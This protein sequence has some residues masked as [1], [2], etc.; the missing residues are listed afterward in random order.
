MLAALHHAGSRLEHLI[1]STSHIRGVL[2]NRHAPLVNQVWWSFGWEE[3]ERPEEVLKGARLGHSASGWKCQTCRRSLAGT[4]E[5]CC[6]FLRV[7]Y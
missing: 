5:R 1:Q 6:T 3:V 2:V 4:M 7:S